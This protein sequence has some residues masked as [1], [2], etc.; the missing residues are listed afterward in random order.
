MAKMSAWPFDSRHPALAGWARPSAGSGLVPS[1]AK[2]SRGT[3][4]G[5]RPT[6]KGRGAPQ[7][8]VLALCLLSAFV[9]LEGAAQEP[10]AAVSPE[11]QRLL[12]QV[13]TDDPSL[14]RRAFLQLE[15]LRE[16]ATASVIRRYLAH[17]SVEL[18]GLS[19][20]ALAAIEGLKAVP[21]LIERLK[22]DRSPA[23]RLQAILAIE[24][25]VALAAERGRR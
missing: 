15:A 2:P 20:R 8:C 10:P 21:E 4:S 12:D 18:R 5:F 3:R 1:E 11:A 19:V 22:Q 23:V 9:S 16:P 24:P 17:R 7:V 13:E 14:R 25:F 6:G